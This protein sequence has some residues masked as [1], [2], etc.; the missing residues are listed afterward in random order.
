[1]SK[2]VWIGF[3]IA[4]AALVA[5]FALFIDNSDEQSRSYQEGAPRQET[6]LDGSISPP[7][8]S[9]ESGFFQ[10]SFYLTLTASGGET[11]RF[12]LDGSEPTA[13]SAEFTSPIPIV[14]PIPTGHN[15]PMTLG[16]RPGPPPRLYYN[17]MVVRARVFDEDGTA[18]PVETRSFFVEREVNGNIRGNFNMRVVSISIE[19]E[20]FAS[21]SGMY[22]SYNLDVRQPAYVEIFY[23][24]GSELLSQYAELRVAGN[25]SRR[26]R[27][28]SLRLNFNRGCGVVESMSLI[29][30]TFQGFHAP[31][32]PVNQF[33]H[34]TLRTADLH[35]TTMREALADRIAEPLRP[36]IQNAVPAAVFVNGEFW[37]MY[38]LR[39][40]R[41]RTFIA[42]RYPGISERSVSMIDFSWNRRN[43]GNHDNCTYAI[44]RRYQDGPDQLY[45]LNPCFGG[46]HAFDGPFGPWLDENG[47]LPRQHPIFRAGVSEGNPSFVYRSWMRMY[48][49]VIGGRVYCD[50]CFAA[51]IM[52]QSCETCRHG[53]EMSRQGDFAAAME[54]VCFDNLV[55]YFI[56]F[57]HF[58]NWDWPGNNKIAWLSDTYYPGVHGGDGKWRFILHDFDNAFWYPRRNNMNL[59]TTPSTGGFAGADGASP[60]RFPYYHD[61]QP[62]WAV[63][64]W[65][66]L[67]ENETFR[68][69]LAARYSTYVGT[70]FST[71]R[72]SGLVNALAQERQDDI[73][74]NFYRWRKHGGGG[75]TEVMEGWRYGVRHLHYFAHVRGDYGIN[76]MRGYFNRDDR[77]HLNLG[78]PANPF[79]IRWQ[80]D[81]ERGWFNIAG[82]EIRPDLFTRD[83][84]TTFDLGNFNASYIWGLPIE[85]TA[86]P[87]YG[88]VFSHFEVVGAV[89]KISTDNPMTLDT[90]ELTP[91]FGPAIVVVTA[92]FE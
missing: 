52:P 50:D 92:V 58:D 41:S 19:P 54:F 70:V 18:S 78:L 15:S 28:K 8:F 57:Y 23:P 72:V 85:V 44:C 49:A 40:H 26:E 89:D 68:N 36:D 51:E 64:F 43:S 2:K 42:A 61:N 63:T 35:V 32:E 81:I 27:K 65:R 80:T 7:A 84:A 87:T 75:F 73:A 79:N 20:Y 33:R 39:E 56:A 12:T 14:A 6:V 66:S 71:A 10:D 86:V 3:I 37:G 74:S 88:Y 53:L 13:N 17:G 9:H 25:W 16:V 46:T 77:P 60:D 55:D 59:F 5:I 76:H 11:I 29:P 21:N 1:M 34:V 47:I 4:T 45:P 90:S 67:L 62:I 31:A 82:A 38:C 91:L 83:G 48:N 22:Q 69:T 24:D 30:D